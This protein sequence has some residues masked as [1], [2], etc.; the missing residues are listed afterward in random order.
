[1]ASELHLP[2]GGISWPGVGGSSSKGHGGSTRL[3]VTWG[4]RGTV[5]LLL[6]WP[7]MKEQLQIKT[8]NERAFPGADL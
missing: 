3:V 6:Q 1:M 8:A 5:Y 2:D 4:K 7:W